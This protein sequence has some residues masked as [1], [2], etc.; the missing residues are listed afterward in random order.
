MHPEHM[1]VSRAD[2]A[3]IIGA[4]EAQI[5]NWM[6]RHGLFGSRN[7]KGRGFH[8]P[9]TIR[10]LMILGAIKELID[11]GI[12]VGLAVGAA[13]RYSVY[14]ALFSGCGELILAPNA[15]RTALIGMDGTDLPVAIRIRAWPIFDRVMRA[16]FPERPN[17][18]EFIDYIRSVTARRRERDSRGEPFEVTTDPW[19]NEVEPIKH[20]DPA[21]LQ[22]AEQRHAENAASWKRA[23]DKVNA[24]Q[25]G[26]SND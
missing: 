24:E 16:W 9:L 18:P 4:T 17:D 8:V 7:L 3:R 12:D 23:I 20:P 22:A 11:A 13:N 21:T 26:D 15:D 6:A 2:A 10:E 25:S 14:G 19:G 1:T 5:S